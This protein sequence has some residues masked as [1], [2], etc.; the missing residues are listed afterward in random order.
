MNEKKVE[1]E[2]RTAE[3]HWKA[4]LAAGR[5]WRC[6]CQACRQERRR[7]RAA[8]ARCIEGVDYVEDEGRVRG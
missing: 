5:P 6:R 1:A 2:R 8:D 7:R 3:R 4:A